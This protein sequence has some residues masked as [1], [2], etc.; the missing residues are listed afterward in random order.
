MRDRRS[1]RLRLMLGGVL[2]VAIVSLAAA[3]WL[4][5]A[6]SEASERAFDR[7]LSR[8]LESLIAAAEVDD[9]G[10]FGLHSEPVDPAFS[11][12]L[13]GHYWRVVAGDRQFQSR[14]LWDGEL[15]VPMPAEAG[16]AQGLDLP[17]PRGLSAEALGRARDNGCAAAGSIGEAVAR[18]AEA[19][20]M[21]VRW[22]APREKDA[23]WPRAARP[24]AGCRPGTGS[25]PWTASR[26]TPTTRSA[27]CCSAWPPRTGRW[28]SR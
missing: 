28:R 20:R 7:E 11:R 22:W 15:A 13:S 6:F 17:G 14:S 24:K 12:P 21:A 5:R 2:G 19:F 3:L 1:L 18:R 8:E 9:A 25:W 26:C 10:R 23:P 16:P 27:R 4:G